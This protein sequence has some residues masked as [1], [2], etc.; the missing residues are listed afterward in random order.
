MRQD[1]HHSILHNCHIIRTL[2]GKRGIPIEA[3]SAIKTLAEKKSLIDTDLARIHSAVLVIGTARALATL[4]ESEETLECAARMRDALPSHFSDQAREW[5][6]MGEQG[7]SSQA[8]FS[9]LTG[10]NL[11]K[12]AN[13]INRA[14]PLDLGGLRRCLLLL[15]RVP[16]FASR[17]QE[18]AQLS[19]EW[20]EL[21]DIWTEITYAIEQKHPDWRR[22]KMDGDMKDVLDLARSHSALGP[23]I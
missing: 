1:Y 7:A 16:E 20:R 10:V 18:V 12:A 3:F 2:E 8:I 21:T 15:E 4:K 13:G 5:A 19:P 17:I 23:K 14:V 6:V 11:S 22:G 9:V